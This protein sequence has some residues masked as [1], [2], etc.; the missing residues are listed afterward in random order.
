MKAETKKRGTLLLAGCA[1]LMDTTTGL[2]LMV[3]PWSALAL[4]GAGAVAE[5]LPFIRFIGAFVFAVGSLYLWGIAWAYRG[6]WGALRS[7]FWSTAWIR[8]VICAFGTAAICRGILDTSWA[9][10]P[11]ADGIV[12]A[13]QLAWLWKGGIPDDA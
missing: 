10:V 3:V 4:M 13:L 6:G 12:A 8:A 9:G 11:A 1:G 2:L 5:A 7:V